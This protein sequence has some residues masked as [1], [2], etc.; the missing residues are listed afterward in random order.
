[1]PVPRVDHE[2]KAHV[3]I[4]KAVELHLALE[5][6]NQV[7]DIQDRYRGR[8]KTLEAQLTTLLGIVEGLQRR[9]DA[10]DNQLEIAKSEALAEQQVEVAQ[11]ATNLLTVNL[12]AD[13]EMAEFSRLREVAAAESRAQL[14]AQATAIDAL[15][16]SV[17]STTALMGERSMPSSTNPIQAPHHCSPGSRPEEGPQRRVELHQGLQQGRASDG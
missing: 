10:K 11:T 4:E 13:A 1:M 2:L 9:I 8:V 16:G 12:Q 3:P 7:L 6:V 17:T 14:E 5:S 15:K